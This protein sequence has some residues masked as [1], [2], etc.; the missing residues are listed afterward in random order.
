MEATA[1]AA[2]PSSFHAPAT[3]KHGSTTFEQLSRLQTRTISMLDAA[4]TIS[5]RCTTHTRE[6]ASVAATV[7]TAS[8]N[9]HLPPQ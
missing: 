7:A 1:P 6:T 9:H 3:H 5:S 8:Q 2:P 4:T